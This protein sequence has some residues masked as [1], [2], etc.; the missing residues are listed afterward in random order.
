MNICKELSNKDVKI[1]KRQ[2]QEKV[3]ARMLI[4]V[5]SLTTF[6]G[7]KADS[8]M[9]HIERCYDKISTFK[10]SLVKK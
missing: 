8:D 10:K 2:F 6:D 1:K 4:S 5:D 9:L 3:S 7:Y